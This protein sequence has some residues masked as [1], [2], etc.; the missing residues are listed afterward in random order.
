VTPEGS[1]RFGDPIARSPRLSDRVAEQLLS[2]ILERD[3]KAGDR[4]PS[5]RELGE[6][7]GVSRTVVRE[8]TRA[9][10]ARGIIDVRAGTGLTVAAVEPSAVASS[11]NLF[12]RGSDVPYADVH[13]VRSVLEGE[14]SGVAAERA[15]ASAVARLREIHG[16]L[17]A[18]HAADDGEAF[19]RV[20]VAF[21]RA[22]A[23][24]TE[25][26]LFIVLLD[27]IGDALLEIRR[28]VSGTGNHDR[29]LAQRH[30]RAAIAYHQQILDAVTAGD[31][32][33]A[34]VAMAEHL[35]DVYRSWANLPVD[36]ASP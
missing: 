29:A 17:L 30:Q 20:D 33:A 12:I 8:A 2:T 9:L 15:N 22:L 31:P 5:E 3:L 21:H 36:T 13:H 6:Q 24:T 4:L 27:A 16:R 14:V 25:N 35:A 1:Q 10:A 34:R 7:F 26:E 32:S 19:A 28:R 11:M 18:E 23:E